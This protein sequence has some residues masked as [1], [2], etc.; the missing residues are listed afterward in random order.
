MKKE[1]VRQGSHVSVIF[2]DDWSI[3][4]QQRDLTINSLSMDENG[5]VYDY[6]GGF[7]DLK[8]NRIRFNGSVA[9][10]IQENPIRILRYFRFEYNKRHDTNRCIIFRF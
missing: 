5:F 4:A 2:T 1:I 9:D 8:Q 3:D 10:R 7:I 6:T